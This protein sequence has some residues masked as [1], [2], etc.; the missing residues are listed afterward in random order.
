MTQLGLNQIRAGFGQFLRQMQ[1]YLQQREAAMN[2][3]V[4]HY[5]AQQHAQARQVSGW[6]ETLTGLTTV[7]DS[8]TGTQFQVFSGP[9]ANYYTNGNGVTINS[10][11]RPDASFL[12]VN[13]VGP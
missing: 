10:N 9:K 5:E 12:Q 3:Q 8:A 13:Q 1:A 6:G 4:A 2:Q 11:L 7:S